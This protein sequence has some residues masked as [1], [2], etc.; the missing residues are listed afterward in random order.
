[1]SLE[2]KIDELIAALAANTA[3]LA[4]GKPFPVSAQA[5]AAPPAKRPPGRPPKKTEDQMIAEAKARVAAVEKTVEDEPENGED[6]AGPTVTK[7]AAAKVLQQIIT[8]SRDEAVNL[9]KKYGASSLGSLPEAK[10]G[11][12]VAEGEEVLLSL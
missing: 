7:E 4:G 8:A 12:F 10:Y 1:M 9:L 11:E 5:D 2:S 6:D 3:A